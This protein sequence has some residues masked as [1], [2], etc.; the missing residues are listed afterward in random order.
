LEIK[1]KKGFCGIPITENGRMGGKLV[2]IVTSRDIDFLEKSTDIPLEHVSFMLSIYFF[3]F[4]TIRMPKGIKFKISVRS[5]LICCPYK[6]ALVET[7]P[8][9]PKDTAFALIV[10]LS[11][12]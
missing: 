7:R 6:G 9:S 2:G 8:G 3:F 11:C 10:N 4:H 12:N 5:F 1:R